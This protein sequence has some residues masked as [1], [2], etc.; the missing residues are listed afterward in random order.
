MYILIVITDNGT[1]HYVIMI[2]QIRGVRLKDTVDVSA[3]KPCLLTLVEGSFISFSLF[4]FYLFFL[5]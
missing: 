4:N 1:L 5:K 2:I 3:L